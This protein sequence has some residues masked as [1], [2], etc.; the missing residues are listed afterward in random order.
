LSAEV[1]DIIKIEYGLLKS[2]NL[3]WNALEQMYGSSNDKRS[4]S[5]NVPEN[6]SSSSMHIDQDQ[7]EQSS[8]QKGKVKFASLEKSD[9]PVS[10]TIVSGFDRTKVI[11]AKEDDC[12][13]SSSDVDD[14]DYDTNNEYYN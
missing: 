13:M 9:G 12:N 1:E 5:T 14:D 7:E 6:I 8:V 11:L 3:L 10:Q 2:A 4:S